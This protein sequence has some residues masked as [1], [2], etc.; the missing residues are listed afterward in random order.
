MLIKTLV[1]EHFYLG[2]LP[3]LLGGIGERI[4]GRAIN[5]EAMPP[6]A[7]LILKLREQIFCRSFL[8]V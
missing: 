1:A 4:L 7:L 5:I 8:S 6:N 3:L 2:G